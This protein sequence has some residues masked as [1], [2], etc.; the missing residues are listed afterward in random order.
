[1]EPKNEGDGGMMCEVHVCTCAF[2]CVCF[3]I[4]GIGVSAGV[5]ETSESGGCSE[6][7]HSVCMYKERKRVEQ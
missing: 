5:K 7:C 2:N 1:M 4:E 3:D 6:C